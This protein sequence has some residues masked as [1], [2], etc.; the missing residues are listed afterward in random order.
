MKSYNKEIDTEKRSTNEKKEI[1][2]DEEAYKQKLEKKRKRRIIIPIISICIF[3]IIAL[4]ST[5]FALFNI[6]N[7]KIISKVSI[8]NILVS[9]LTRKELENKLNKQIEEKLEKEIILKTGEFEYSIK[10]NQIDASY[11]VQKAVEDAYNVGRNGNIFTNNFEIIKTITKGKNIELEFEYNDKLLNDIITDI[12]LKIPGAVEEPSYYIDGD[13]LHIIKGKEGN[14]ID[15]ESLKNKI[16]DFLKNNCQEMK[17]DLE[18]I[19]KKPEAIDIEKI[20]NEVHTEPKNAYYTKDPFQIYP[21][22]D[23]IN[24]NLDDAKELLK[25]DKEEYEIK[26]EITHPDVT[27]GD[28]GTEAFPDLLSSFSTKYDASNVSRTNNLILAMR[29]LDGVV[30]NPGEVFS[31]NKTLG[32]RT[33]AKGYREAGGFAGGRVV[34][35]VGGG[36]CQI[37]STL[38]N[39]AVYA[40]LEIVERHNH[41][42]I[43]GYV[44]AGK[45][46]TVSYGTLDFKFKNTRKYPIIIKTSI[47]SGIAKVSIFGIKEEA[48][49]EIEISTKILNYTQYSTIYEDDYSLPE[50]VE[51]VEQYGM[52]GCKSITYKIVK[53]NG[54]QVSST[55]LSTDTY[56]PMSKIIK[57][58]AK[59]TIQTSNEPEQIDEHTPEQ[60]E[61]QTQEQEMPKPQPEEP[62]PEEPKPETPETPETPGVEPTPNEENQN[63]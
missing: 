55:V 28:L 11:N 45:D 13:K 3:I 9:G 21:H 47:G 30:V 41:M 42:F 35:M 33:R 19:N 8:E 32:Q 56:D 38:Y 51:K 50:G 7:N 23:G 17:I 4:F 20:Y 6:K 46:A 36:I 63:P 24:F 52:N 14:T 25:E 5:G 26:L 58:G 60:E 10:L 39:A 27:T 59:K 54:Q 31:Y 61:P 44:G 29:S 62:K 18:V 34:Q 53:L 12:S 1:I 2:F 49:Y 57:R 22:E 48:E 16:I 40:N 43:A 15:K 37:S